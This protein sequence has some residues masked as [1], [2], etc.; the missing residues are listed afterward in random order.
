MITGSVNQADE[1]CPLNV[2]NIFRAG[3][4]VAVKVKKYCDISAD[5]LAVIRQDRPKGL[6]I[7]GCG[8]LFQTKIGSQD[9]GARPQLVAASI[10]EFVDYRTA[11]N[12]GIIRAA[13]YIVL[14]RLHDSHKR[15]NLRYRE[16]HD[17]QQ[18]QLTAKGR[19][20]IHFRRRVQESGSKTS[21]PAQILRTSR[22]APDPCNIVKKTVQSV[23]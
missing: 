10:K 18:E 15:N 16:W 6:S 9:L 8:S 3:Q 5:T 2:A 17:R 11:D 1:F 19:S 7:A 13:V 21:A 14:D 22:T 23:Y 12:Q 4:A 20:K